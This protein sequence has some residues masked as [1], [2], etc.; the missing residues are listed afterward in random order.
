MS[1]NINNQAGQNK[2]SI[3][4]N[5]DL[6]QFNTKN[7]EQNKPVAKSQDSVQLTSQAK[8]LHKLHNDNNNEVNATRI[9]ELKAAI[10]NGDYKINVEHLAERLSK[11]EG[12]FS[13]YNPTE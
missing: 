3:D 1:I 8:N 6:N 2:V 10:I 9:E 5:K 11:F 12:D 13:K 7:E 4:K